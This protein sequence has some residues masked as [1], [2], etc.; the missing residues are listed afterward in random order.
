MKPRSLESVKLAF[1][2]GEKPYREYK[3]TKASGEVVDLNEVDLEEI[4]KFHRFR[5]T[6]GFLAWLKYKI[7]LKGGSD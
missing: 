5:K 7:K 3:F 6:Y 2:I 4:A 1:D